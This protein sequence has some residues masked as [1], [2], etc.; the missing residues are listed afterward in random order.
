MKNESPP[1]S[2]R[3]RQIM[4]VVYR[5]GPA[6]VAQ[7]REAMAD[8]PSYSSVRTLMGLLEEKGHL[9]HAQVGTRYVYRPTIPTEVAGK[10]ALTDLVR[11][12]FGGS[13]EG[14]VSTLIDADDVDPSTLDQLAEL[15]ESAR[16]KTR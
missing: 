9:T 15:V 13:I 8:P 14:M 7:V 10:R 2:R 16:K 1:L 11:T 4:D 12:F 5:I 6:S 3:E